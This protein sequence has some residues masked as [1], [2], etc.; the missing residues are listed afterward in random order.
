MFL[1]SFCVSAADGTIHVVDWLRRE[2]S[3]QASFP[4]VSQRRCFGNS[5]FQD[6]AAELA[7]RFTLG[8]L[9]LLAIALTTSHF[10]QRR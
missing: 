5:C 2:T 4:R 6:V 1:W 7:S 3:C 9:S 10:E 8:F